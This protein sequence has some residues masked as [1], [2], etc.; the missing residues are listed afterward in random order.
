MP[1]AKYV[2]PTSAATVACKIYPAVTRFP[3]AN[4]LAA[5]VA[6]VLPRSLQPARPGPDLC[7]PPGHALR[8]HESLLLRTRFVDVFA[9]SVVLRPVSGSSTPTG[10]ELPCV[11]RAVWMTAPQQSPSISRPACRMRDGSVPHAVTEA[12]CVSGFFWLV[13]WPSFSSSSFRQSVRPSVRPTVPSQPHPSS[14][15]AHR[16]R[17]VRRRRVLLTRVHRARFSPQCGGGG[18]GGGGRGGPGCGGPGLRALL[19]RH[20]PLRPH[21]LSWSPHTHRPHS[22]SPREARPITSVCRREP[23]RGGG[24]GGGGSARRRLALGV[25]AGRLRRRP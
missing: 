15:P 25:Q 7:S 8:C 18:G 6:G 24:G 11:P 20:R 13:A 23:A 16:S 1:A 9:C 14:A 10:R 12:P 21:P 22:T 17:R 2:L 3:C 5:Q 19:P 4:L